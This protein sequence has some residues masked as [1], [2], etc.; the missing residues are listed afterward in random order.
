M[1]TLNP[2]RLT[3]KLQQICSLESI[4]FSLQPLRTSLVCLNPDNSIKQ[5]HIYLKLR[6]KLNTAIALAI[7]HF[8]PILNREF[9]EL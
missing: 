2:A 8:Y 3:M 4:E 6:L 9:W 5:Y 7:E 1:K